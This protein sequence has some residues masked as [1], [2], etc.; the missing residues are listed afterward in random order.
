MI[1]FTGGVWDTLLNISQLYFAYNQCVTKVTKY[2]VK[3]T[4]T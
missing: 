2:S 1:R 4:L 3:S